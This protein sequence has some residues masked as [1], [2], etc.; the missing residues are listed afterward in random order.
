MTQESSCG[1]G[2]VSQGAWTNQYSPSYQSQQCIKKG[3]NEHKTRKMMMSTQNHQKR[4]VFQD[5]H[6]GFICTVTMKEP[7]KIIDC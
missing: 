6:V 3:C 7:F 1:I 2:N 5:V 4:H